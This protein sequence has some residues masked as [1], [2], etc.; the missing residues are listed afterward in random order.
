MAEEIDPGADAPKTFTQAELDQ[1][2]G[3]RL[4][5]E[6]AA[7]AEKYADYDEL[8]TKAA[9][10]DTATEAAK[11]EMEKLNGKVS[12]LTD[13]LAAERHQ[14]S[15]AAVATAKGLTPAHVK[16][17]ERDAKDAKSRSEIETLADELLTD[18]PLPTK[19]AEETNEAGGADD[20]TPVPDKADDATDDAARGALNTKPVQNLKAGKGDPD[21]AV[22]ETDPAKLAAAIPRR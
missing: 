15:I 17:L 16:R 13:D 4:N 18:F 22:T 3:E 1:K 21:G 14:A 2:I 20:K 6:R 11:S 9:A 10:A 5:R 7:T 12:K 19:G 8:K